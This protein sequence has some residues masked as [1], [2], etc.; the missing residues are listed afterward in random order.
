LRNGGWIAVVVVLVMSVSGLYVGR[1][2]LSEIPDRAI[3]H[4]PA[5]PEAGLPRDKSIEYTVSGPAGTAAQVSYLGS[6]GRAQ[7][8]QVVLP[9]RKVVTTREFT[10][11]AGVLAQVSGSGSVSCTVRIN[12]VQRASERGSGPAGTAAVNCAVPVA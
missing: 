12:G 11:A 2:R 3:G 4:A 8:E 7:D 5:A 6:A 9:W 10:V 1:L